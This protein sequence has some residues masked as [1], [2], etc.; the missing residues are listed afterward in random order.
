MVE[1][2]ARAVER[3]CNI[4]WKGGSTHRWYYRSGEI[5]SSSLSCTSFFLKVILL[6]IVC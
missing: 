4:G 3:C 5:I 2:A 1:A 6:M